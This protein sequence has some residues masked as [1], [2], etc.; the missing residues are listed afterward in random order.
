[1]KLFT[2]KSLITLL[3]NSVVTKVISFVLVIV[4]LLLAEVV[5][6]NASD[7]IEEGFIT[8][9]ITQYAANNDTNAYQS[10]ISIIQ[11]NGQDNQA[12]VMQSRSASYQ[13]G[14]FAKIS[15]WGNNNQASIMQHNGANIGIIWQEGNN[16]TAT[17]VQEGKSLSFRAEIHQ[18]GLSSDIQISQSGSGLRSISVEQHNYSGNAPPVTIDNY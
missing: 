3:Q 12:S 10:N 14:N 18:V 11:Q 15:Q 13:L 5:T 7:N 4:A 2:M 1:M 9:R 17:L 6:A 16:H 8:A